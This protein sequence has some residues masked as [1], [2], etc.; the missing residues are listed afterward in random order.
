MSAIH[1]SLRAAERIRLRTQ[2]IQVVGPML[3][4]GSALGQALRS[5]VGRPDLVSFGM[6]ELQFNDIGMPALFVHKTTTLAMKLAPLVFVRP[7]ELRAAEW[8]E[9]HLDRAE[10]RIPEQ[11]QPSFFVRQPVQSL[12]T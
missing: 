6:G 1:S 2:A 3:H 4:H 10:W 7:G 11:G 8:K 5:V 9:F 12:A